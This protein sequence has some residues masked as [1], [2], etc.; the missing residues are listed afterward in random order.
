MAGGRP[1]YASAVDSSGT[2]ISTTFDSSGNYVF[3]G[4]PSSYPVALVYR[5][6]QTL[7]NFDSTASDIVGPPQ[8]APTTS[9]FAPPISVQATYAA[10]TALG[11]PSVNTLYVVTA[12]ENKSYV[13]STYLWLSNGSRLWIAS[14]GDN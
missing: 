11:T 10:M 12:D 9:S 1:T 8:T 4:T 6:Q 14:T 2:I 13:N 5:V 3:S 7:V